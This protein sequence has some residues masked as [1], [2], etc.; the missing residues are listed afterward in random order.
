MPEYAKVCQN[1]PG[2]ARVCQ[3]VF[4][5]C[6]DCVQSVFRVCSECH[7]SVIRVSS[8]CHQSVIRVCSLGHQSVFR[9]SSEW[10]HI[11][12]ILPHC[13]EGTQYNKWCHRYCIL[14]SVHTAPNAMP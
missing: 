7:Q 11:S 6:S 10:V 2:Y 4:R 9:G 5:V 13:P 1:M 14:G 3:S 8:E 12:F